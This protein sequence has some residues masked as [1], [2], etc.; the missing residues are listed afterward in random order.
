[1][2]PDNVVEAIQTLNPDGVDVSGGVETNGVKDLAKI[3]RFI[4][5]VRGAGISHVR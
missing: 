2:T 5:V 4:A 3:E 1:L